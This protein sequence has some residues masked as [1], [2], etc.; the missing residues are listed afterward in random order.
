MSADSVTKTE[1]LQK[2]ARSSRMVSLVC[3]LVAACVVCAAYLSWFRDQSPVVVF[4]LVVSVIAK[5]LEQRALES[6]AR[7]H[8]N[9]MA[10]DLKQFVAQEFLM[11]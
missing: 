2:I 6:I 3:L 1:M 11:E 4:L 7:K 10:E 8:A 5:A 9:H